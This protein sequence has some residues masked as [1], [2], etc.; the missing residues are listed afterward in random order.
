MYAAIYITHLVL[1]KNDICLNLKRI[2]DFFSTGLFFIS[3]PCR[4]SLDSW[5]LLH[6]NHDQHQD[7]K[8]QQSQE[9]CK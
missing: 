2:Q 9:L 6:F 8:K 4:R 7:N 5:I 1:F 3:A